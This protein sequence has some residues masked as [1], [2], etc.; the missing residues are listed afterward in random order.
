MDAL[1]VNFLI[2]ISL[3]CILFLLGTG[4]SLTM[5]LMR[6]ANLAHGGLYMVGAFVGLAVAK[7]TGNFGLGI[8]AGGACAGVLGLIIEMGF[9]R[10][11]YKRDLDQVLL[12]IGF[13]YILTNLIQ[14][15]WGATPMSGVVPSFL[16]GSISV[17][18]ITFPVFRLA[19][20]VFGIIAAAGLW[21]FQEKTRVGAI[22][23]AGMD[24]KE[25]T[26]GLGINLKVVFSGVFALGSFIAGF[27]GLIG[28][29]FLGINL[30]LG[31][32][33]LLLAMIVVIIGGTGS[34]QGALIGGIVIGLVDAYGKAFF[35]NF[36]YFSM[37]LV[38]IIILLFR[39][40]GLLGKAITGQQAAETLPPA[41]KL[42]KEPGAGMKAGLAVSGRSWRSWGLS[43]APYIGF[44]L[45]LLVLPPILPTYFLN[46]LTKVLIFAIFA[47]SL[48]LILGYTG[49]P[50]LGHAAFLGVAGYAVGILMVRYGIES[51]WLVIPLAI[52]VAG[53]VAAIT[54]YISLRVSGVYFLL[55]TLAFG[56]LL[57]IVALKWRAMT[58]G[59]DGLTGI[60]Y[61]LLGIPG[62]TWTSSSF[63]YL[64]F[65]A[66]V[67][68]F[69]L[70]Y[71]IT[72]SSFGRALVGIREN[73]SR[74]QSLGYNTWAHKYIAF[75]IAGIFAGVAGALF[76]PFYGIMVPTNLGI[77]TS[78]LVMLMVIIGG[79]GTLFGPI[80]GA[81][82]IV[83]LEHFASIY[84]PE[85]WP[86]VLGGVFVLCVLF[87]RGGVGPYLSRLWQKVRFQ[88]GSVKS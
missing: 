49:L 18:G 7:S 17:S 62:F 8:L 13:I 83:L 45:L 72:R 42:D 11:L 15:I 6:I 5:G 12:T 1:L 80:I 41:P 22:I 9:L 65:I 32:D 79:A 85:R 10:R 87:M 27:C 35:P 21:L 68:C 37:Y 47:M 14:W 70:L 75:I 19:I 50:S 25:M 66:F 24:D 26:M 55:V 73:E 36:A 20:I 59:T 54:G 88:Y 30:S 51:I 76:A 61:P 34:I 60:G 28:A 58:G 64:V 57:S 3:G 78:A 33:A 84:S 71:L 77:T 31:W 2:G 16:S 86:L 53:F 39:P 38:L 52:L 82:L 56:E 43:F 67:I 81:A 44:G 46:M 48:D 29:P 63:Y 40:S 74:M 69:I 23:R 4:L